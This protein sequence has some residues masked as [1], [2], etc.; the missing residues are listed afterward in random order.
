MPHDNTELTQYKKSRPQR[1]SPTRCFFFFPVI[2]LTASLWVVHSDRHTHHTPHTHTHTHTH[3]HTAVPDTLQLH[4]HKSLRVQGFPGHTPHP[5]L[6]PH[7][8]RF[9]V[10]DKQ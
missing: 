1:S 10:D 6:H 8:E 5:H 7:S 4:L 9:D 3:A 2:R